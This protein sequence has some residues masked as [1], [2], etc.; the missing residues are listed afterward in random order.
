MLNNFSHIAKIVKMLHQ[1]IQ[2]KVKSTKASKM[3]KSK[4]LV[5]WSYPPGHHPV[6]L[7]SLS[8]CKVYHFFMLFTSLGLLSP[9][10]GVP[11]SGTDQ[12]E[13]K[14]RQNS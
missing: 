3:N 4:W 6:R 11:G 12:L 5:N 9:S 13:C 2:Q 8:A 1:P 7:P 10:L 14:D